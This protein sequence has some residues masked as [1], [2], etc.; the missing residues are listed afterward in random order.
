MKPDGSTETV[1]VVYPVTATGPGMANDS[2]KHWACRCF[3]WSLVTSEYE[4]SY[5]CSRAADTTL[6]ERRKQ[7]L[8]TQEIPLHLVT[9]PNM[10][11]VAKQS[12]II[13]LPV[14]AFYGRG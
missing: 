7:V 14:P 11:A 8:M 1:D 4:R 6:K 2:F 13:F 9:L 10:A 12:G 3:I 5:D